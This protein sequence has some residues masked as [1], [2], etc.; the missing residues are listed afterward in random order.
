MRIRRCLIK[1]IIG[2]FSKS[3]QCVSMLRLPIIFDSQRQSDPEVAAVPGPWNTCLRISPNLGKKIAPIC[4]DTSYLNSEP[5][6]GSRR[7][8]SFLNWH[9][10]LILRQFGRSYLSFVEFTSSDSDCAQYV[11]R[12]LYRIAS[13]VR[14]TQRLHYIRPHGYL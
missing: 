8:T 9:S 5:L 14:G 4:C 13:N 12:R 2:H 3:V 11:S 7:G 1:R 10:M 6:C